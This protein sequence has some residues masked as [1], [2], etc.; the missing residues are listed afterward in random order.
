MHALAV[1]VMLAVAAGESFDASMKK[2]VA[3]YNE[4][5]W[6]A[7]LRELTL[8]ESLAAT[9][10][11]RESAWLHQGVVLA[12]V[13]DAEA[14]R[15]AW[16]RALERAPSAELP[17]PVSPRVKALFVEVQKQVQD[18]LAAQPRTRVLTPSQSDADEGKFPLVPVVSLGAGLLSG[19]VGLAFALLSNASLQA[20]GMA[21]TN[22]EREG[23][24]SRAGL[25]STI[26][27]IAFAVAGVAALTAL[28]TF[29]VLD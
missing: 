13:P 15:A 2:A 29:I 22:E 3:L 5:E 11:Q 4:A 1:T 24:R 19:G 20:S 17:V 10:A 25:Q 14:A 23:L 8:A 6:D 16:R 21:T 26:A 28:I 7:A 18:T 12:N 27:N 9:D